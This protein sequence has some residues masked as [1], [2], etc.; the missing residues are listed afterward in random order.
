L[1]VVQK[2][3]EKYLIEKYI[4]LKTIKTNPK[5]TRYWLRAR[6]TKLG[7]NMY[8]QLFKNILEEL[9]KESLV[10]LDLEKDESYSITIT[11]KGMSAIKDLEL[12]IKFILTING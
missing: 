10:R 1:G 6:L 7:Y 8:D 11:N 3:K 12:K 5:S 9:C 4:L 2:L